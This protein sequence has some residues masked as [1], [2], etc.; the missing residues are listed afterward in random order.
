MEAIGR[1]GSQCLIAGPLAVARTQG[2][3]AA[4]AAPGFRALGSGSDLQGGGGSTQSLCQWQ[5][6]DVCIP[7]GVKAKGGAWL[8]CPPQR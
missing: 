8:Q 2:E 6:Q 7:R 4:Q 3:V 5:Q 1:A